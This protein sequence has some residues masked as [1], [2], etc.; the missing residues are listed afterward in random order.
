MRFARKSPFEV[1][2]KPDA[3]LKE[4]SDMTE[5]VTAEVILRSA[6]GSSILEAKEPITA[7]N[8]ARYRIGKE[9]IEEASQKLEELGFEALQGGP[10]GLTISGDKARFEDVFQTTLTAQSTGIMETKV[11]GAGAAY[12]ETTEPIKVPED[13]SYLIADVVF[14]TPP[15]FFP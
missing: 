6:D 12:Y 7:E 3:K 13:L 15:Q 1:L 10:T 9:V 11:S 4:T 5:Q 8:I 14:A 2:S